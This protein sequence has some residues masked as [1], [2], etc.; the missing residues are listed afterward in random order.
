MPSPIVH[1]S[2]DDLPLVVVGLEHTVVHYEA[3]PDHSEGHS[4]GVPQG[5]GVQNTV[6]G[7][8]ISKLRRGGLG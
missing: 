5:V 1:R 8:E 4:G 7:R 2:L 3:P 6:V